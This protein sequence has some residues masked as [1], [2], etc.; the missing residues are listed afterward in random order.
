MRER[1][2]C[3]TSSKMVREGLTKKTVIVESG[4]KESAVRIMWEANLGH[5]GTSTKGL[6]I[7]T[8]GG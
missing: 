3:S 6:T 2:W 4:H 1:A 7:L 8:H 5:E